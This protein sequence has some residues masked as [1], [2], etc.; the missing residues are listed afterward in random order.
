MYAGTYTANAPA[1]G[2]RTRILTMRLVVCTLGSGKRRR[3][4]ALEACD[5]ET[6]Q[7]FT[8][9]HQDQGTKTSDFGHDSDTYCL[10]QRVYPLAIMA[11]SDE[12]IHGS[13]PDPERLWKVAQKVEEKQLWAAFL[14]EQEHTI[15]RKS[16]RRPETWSEFLDGRGEPIES[17][18]SQDSGGIADGITKDGQNGEKVADP[19][20]TAFRT[21][22]MFSDLSLKK[23]FPPQSGKDSIGLDVDLYPENIEEKVEPPEEKPKARDIEEDDYDDDDE[24]ADVNISVPELPQQDGDSSMDTIGMFNLLAYDRRYPSFTS[25]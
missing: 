19:V 12:Q 15:W 17:A 13:W 11:S 2:Q 18:A 1:T 22:M 5:S 6:D 25:N 20:S 14:S 10:A 3:R 7:A 8:R 21:R 24:D 23:L 4:S 9:D 16:L